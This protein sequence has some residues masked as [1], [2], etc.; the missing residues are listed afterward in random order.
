MFELYLKDT[1]K[2]ARK[3]EVYFFFFT[4]SAVYIRALAQRYSFVFLLKLLLYQKNLKGIIHLPTITNII[5]LLFI[6]N[7]IFF[8]KISGNGK[9]R[10]IRNCICCQSCRGEYRGIISIGGVATMH[11]PLRCPVWDS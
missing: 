11:I 2:R 1:H 9:R 7:S 3:N 8:E 5:H 4:A 10:T 6:K